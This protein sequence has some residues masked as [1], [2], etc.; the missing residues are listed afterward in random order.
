[1]ETLPEFDYDAVF[2][3]DDYL[4]F[5][6]ES[7]T[8]DRSDA[9]VAGLVQMA[10][11]DTP[12]KILDMPC[13]IGRH[14]NRLAALG[15]TMTGVDLYPGFLEI[16]RREADA[17]GVHVDY[18]QADM[19]HIDYKNEYDRVMILFTSFGFF[20]DED[21]YLVLQNAARALVPGGLFILDIP[22]RDTFIKYTNPAYVVEKNGDL[23]ID[24]INFDT[25]TGKMHNRRIVI[26]NGVRKDK[27]FFVRLFSPS[28]ISAWIKRAGMEIVQIFGGY[29]AVP[30]TVDSRHMIVVAKLFE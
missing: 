7:L 16:A 26:R 6:S 19:R 17:R 25:C 13:G 23:M 14:T 22:N 20:E 18:Q 30:I 10:Q 9:E 4:Y 27:P 5:Y 24:R 2:E 15:H 3:V 1:M 11:L 12:Q 29:N 28:E 21:N 8:D